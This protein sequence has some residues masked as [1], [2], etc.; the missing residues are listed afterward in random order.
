MN[1]NVVKG[2]VDFYEGDWPS[3]IGIL[4]SFCG[5]GTLSFPY[6]SQEALDAAN[7]VADISAGIAK[8]KSG[9]VVLEFP[10]G[11]KLRIMADDKGNPMYLECPKKELRAYGLD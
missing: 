6:D 3:I 2:W 1:Y 4:E 11:A 8:R 9:N 5:L 10:N 7:L